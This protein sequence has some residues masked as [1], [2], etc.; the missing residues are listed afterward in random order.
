MASLAR[1]S[2]KNTTTQR[3]KKPYNASSHAVTTSPSR[4]A[5]RKPATATRPGLIQL[6]ETLDTHRV[7]SANDWQCSTTDD[8]GNWLF[9]Y[10]GVRPKPENSPEEDEVVNDF[11]RLDLRTHVWED[12]TVS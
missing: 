3:K 4:T 9:V 10:G 1:R 5:A 12:L 6:K 8:T 7:P 2:T 11:W